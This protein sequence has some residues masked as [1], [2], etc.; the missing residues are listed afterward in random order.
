M[1]FQFVSGQNNTNSPYTRFAYG[2]LSDNNSGEQ[3]AMGGLSIG[4][5]D[6]ASI[7]TVNPASYSTVD[8]LTFMFDIGVSVLGSRFTEPAGNKTSLTSNLEY[9]TLQFPLA[10]NMGFSAGLL[11]YSFSGYNFYNNDTLNLDIYPD[12]VSYTES[13]YGSGSISQIYA[14]L[15]YNFFNHLSVGVNAYYM[16]G[17][18]LNVKDL[19]FSNTTDFHE[20]YQSKEMEVSNFRFR[21]GLQFYNTFAK[22]HTLTL[23]AIYEPKAK[24][25][26]TYSEYTSGVLLEYTPDSTFNNNFET[27]EIFGLGLNY[28]YN[29]SLNIGID[30]SLQKWG[31]ALYFGKTDSLN[32]RSKISLGAEYVPNP[33][34]RKYSDRI[35]YRVGFN[36]TDPYYNVNGNTSNKNFGIS[37]GIGLP[38]RGTPAL[39]N[40]TF[41]YGKVGSSSMLREDY[42]RFTLNVPFIESWFFKQKL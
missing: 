13:Y 38:L 11:P 20:T 34:S 35:H 14:G 8:S 12:T 3:R 32:N 26:G 28:S 25:N 41:E 21:Y 27:P 23:G 24:L 17:S 31:D 30:Y 19:S 15:S 1:T 10:K 4:L 18:V 29:N 40:A 6:K 33:M 16:F 37:F 39:V 22:K 5:R 42:M 9:I 2:E 36:T 7:N